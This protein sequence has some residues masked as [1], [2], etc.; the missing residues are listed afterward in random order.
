MKLKKQNQWKNEYL[1][2]LHSGPSSNADWPLAAEL[3][4][5]EM[6]RGKFIL[7]GRTRDGIANLQWHGITTQGRLFADDL[8]DKI[9]RS[10]W[11]YRTKLATGGFL[12]WLAGYASQKGLDYWIER[13]FGI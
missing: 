9:R 11:T 10:T 1:R 7:D 8:A 12:L 3:I 13:F 5:E 2:I 4:Q 6:A